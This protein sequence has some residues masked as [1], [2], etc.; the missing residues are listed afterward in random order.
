MKILAA[1]LIDK[2]KNEEAIEH[3]NMAIRMNPGKAISYNAR[4][5]AYVTL[6]QHQHGHRGLQ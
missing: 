1:A 2:G 6:G 5:T 4:G 3:C